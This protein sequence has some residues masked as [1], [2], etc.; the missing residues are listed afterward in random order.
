M[1]VRRI[2]FVAV[3]VGVGAALYDGGTSPPTDSPPFGPGTSGDADAEAGGSAGVVVS[4]AVLSGAAQAL[5]PARSEAPN[6]P[7]TARL[8]GVDM[9]TAEWSPHMAVP[10][11]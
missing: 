6:T 1:N 7:K 8:A 10:Q 5:K 11:G 2:R 4:G 9:G 3:G